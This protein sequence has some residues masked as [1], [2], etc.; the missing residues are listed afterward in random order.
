MLQVFRGK[1]NIGVLTKTGNTTA[2]L[3]NTNIV[4]GAKQYQTGNLVLDINTT[5]LGGLENPKQINSFYY[6]YLVESSNSVY[7]IGSTSKEKPSGYSKYRKVGAISTNSSNL[8]LD[9]ASGTVFK[10]CQT[11]FLTG[12]ITSDTNDIVDLKFNNLPL[13]SKF[14]I[15]G[16]AYLDVTAEDQQVLFDIENN[17]ESVG[18]RF[19]AG[20]RDDGNAGTQQAIH[21]GNLYAEFETS[22]STLFSQISSLSSAGNGSSLRGNSTKVQTFLTLCSIPDGYDAVIE[23]NEWF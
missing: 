16:L 23:T 9:A 20:S 22:A 5:G 1:E 7:L 21:A 15:S 11:K 13:N 17:S 6:I 4:F 8:I 10:K 3:S 19:S 14:Q 2:Q 18:A 12:D